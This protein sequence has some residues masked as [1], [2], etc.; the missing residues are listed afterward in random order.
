MAAG[1][2]EKKTENEMSR[3]NTSQPVYHLLILDR[4]YNPNSDI[5]DTGGMRVLYKYK[6][7]RNGYLIALYVSPKDGPVFPKLPARSRIVL[8]LSTARPDTIREYI[9]SNAFRR[10]VTSRVI[11][12]R[13]LEALRRR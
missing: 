11:S 8:N 1:G 7:G 4:V 2:N 5:S 6:H 13:L 12:S 10:F 9:N 3:L